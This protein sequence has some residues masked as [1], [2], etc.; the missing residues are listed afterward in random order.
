MPP[1][2]RIVSNDLLRCPNDCEHPLTVLAK[3]DVRPGAHRE[4]EA[5]FRKATEIQKNQFTGYLAS[6][7]IRPLEGDSTE[8]ISI[9]RYDSYAHLQTWMDSTARQ[10][11]LQEVATLDQAPI[12]FSY[13]ALE[14]FFS[15]NTPTAPKPPAKWKMV[16]VLTAVVFSQLQWVPFAVESTLPFL[17]VMLQMLLTVFVIVNLAQFVVLPILTRLLAFWLFPERDYVASL[18]ELVPV[19]IRRRNSDATETT[20]KPAK[21]VRL[22]SALGSTERSSQP[23]STTSDRPEEVD[24]AV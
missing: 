14:H 1:T 24:S 16:V 15:Q 3:H 21:M 19:W 23:S 6:E 18:R 4:F 11:L 17:P 13:H 9:F 12:Q 2:D 20:T 22:E 7:L 10:E 5:W 8:Y